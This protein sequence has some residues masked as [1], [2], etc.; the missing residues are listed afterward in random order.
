MLVPNAVNTLILVFRRMV[1]MEQPLL[2][3]LY[4]LT[5]F[6]LRLVVYPWMLYLVTLEMKAFPFWQGAIAFACQ[7]VLVIFQ[8]GVVV[9]AVMEVQRKKAGRPPPKRGVGAPVALLGRARQRPAPPAVQRM[10][11]G[12]SALLGKA[13]MSP[14]GDLGRAA[15]TSDRPAAAV[16]M[17]GPVCQQRDSSRPVLLAGRWRGSLNKGRAVHQAW[18]SELGARPAVRIM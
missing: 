6:P 9:L 15:R 7:S 11:C 3:V 5:F 18:L 10:A 2:K 8:I 14:V 4:W 16:G 12:R 1:G 17:L 13:S